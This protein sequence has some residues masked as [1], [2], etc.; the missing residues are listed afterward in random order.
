MEDILNSSLKLGIVGGGQLGRL[1]AEKASR[2]N[3]EVSFLDGDTEAPAK[4]ICN[5]FQQ[6]SINSYDDVLNFGKGLDFVTIESDSVNADALIALD[7]QGV[8]TYPK[9]EVL[10]IIQNKGDQREFYKKHDLPSPE[11]KRYSSKE[12]LLKALDNNDFSLPKIIKTCSS[13]YDG[14]GVFLV[15][16]PKDLDSVPDV[17][18]LVEEVV[19]IKREFS[20]IAVRSS[21]GEVVSY[22]LIE[23]FMHSDAYLV[24]YLVS[25]VNLDSQLESKAKQIAESL[26]EKLE[27]VGIL[28]VEM[29][30]DDKDQLYINECSPRP[31]NSGHQTIEGSFT[32]QY[33]QHLRAIFGLPLGNCEMKVPAAMV[34]LLGDDS[35]SGKP[36]YRGLEECLKIPGANIHIY[37]KK[38]TRPNRKM[39]HVTIVDSDVKKLSSGIEKVKKE[40]GVGI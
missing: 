12:E 15:K 25:P 19:N 11:F 38:E 39:G 36:K 21:K 22:P 3:V 28:A 18:L 34:N 31:H 20:A 24:D 13:G 40:L 37:G 27:H 4:I 33:E 10:K 30:L 23:L 2:W 7:K 26:V 9:G 17:E 14:K 29:F 5:N 1:L 8:K 16:S 35:G 6:G 32:S